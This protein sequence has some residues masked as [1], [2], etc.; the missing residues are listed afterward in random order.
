MIFF[1]ADSTYVCT[2]NGLFL[3]FSMFLVAVW[4]K[5]SKDDSNVHK[6]YERWKKS[7]LKLK[8]RL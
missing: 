6:F 7:I 3:S 2:N 8:R 5:T 4:H 1:L